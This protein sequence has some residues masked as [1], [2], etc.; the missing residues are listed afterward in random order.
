MKET[1]VPGEKPRLTPSHWQLSYMPRPGFEP[2]PKSIENTYLDKLHNKT[3]NLKHIE[4]AHDLTIG[5][6]S[7]MLLSCSRILVKDRR[8]SLMIYLLYNRILVEDRRGSLMIS[9]LYKLDIGGRS[10]RMDDDSS[11]Q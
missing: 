8:G 5:H 4:L 9:P 2:I 6:F 3:R 1:G 11:S 10:T 7:V